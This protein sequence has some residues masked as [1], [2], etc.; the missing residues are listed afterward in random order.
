MKIIALGILLISSIAFAN[1]DDPLLRM[2][3]FVGFAPVPGM[4]VLTIDNLG[5]VEYESPDSSQARK[6]KMVTLAQLS[7]EAIKNL[8]VKVAQLDPMARL[9]DEDP[10][11][12]QCMDAPAVNMTAFQAGKEI[13]FYAS[14]SCHS[15]YM[16]DGNGYDLVQLLAGLEH[17][18]VE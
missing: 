5:K 1:T 6:M 13:R 16:E 10:E 8:K 18:A 17:L 11:G 3:S 9:I 12:P 14:E 15:F 4:R 7:V 2:S